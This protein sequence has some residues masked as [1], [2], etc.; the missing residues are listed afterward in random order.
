MDAVNDRIVA[1]VR[2]IFPMFWTLVV[3]FLVTR[4]PVLAPAQ[5]WLSGL[6]EGL[7]TLGIGAVVYPVLR[8]LEARMPNW[9]ARILM[10]SVKQPTY[11]PPAPEAGGVTG[12]S[13]EGTL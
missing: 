5:D 9:L 10:G 11:V 6:G 12:A 8:W 7:L 4:I 3:G 1:W 13:G 2:T